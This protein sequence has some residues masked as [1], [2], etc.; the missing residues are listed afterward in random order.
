MTKYRY[1]WLKRWNVH[2]PTG[3]DVMGVSE[4]ATFEYWDDFELPG[5]DD[6]EEIRAEVVKQ[7]HAET[8]SGGAEKKKRNS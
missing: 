8:V 4:R 3:R 7:V 2:Q 1:Q 6:I 5:S